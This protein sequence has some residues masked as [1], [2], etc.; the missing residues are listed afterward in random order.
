MRQMQLPPWATRDEREQ[1]EERLRQRVRLMLDLLGTTARQVAATLRFL[2]IRGNPGCP[3][4]CPLAVYLGAWCGLRDAYVDV[5]NLAFTP[6][7]GHMWLLWMNLEETPPGD[8]AER[9]DDG[10]FR[11]LRHN[12]RR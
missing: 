4:N 1:F 8:F 3:R 11:W 2:G 9:F 7:E 10:R 5:S 12:T 6:L